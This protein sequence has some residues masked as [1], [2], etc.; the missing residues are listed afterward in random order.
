MVAP[1]EPLAAAGVFHRHVLVVRHARVHLCARWPSIAAA[2]HLPLLVQKVLVE[3][4][5]EDCARDRRHPVDLR[6]EFIRFCTKLNEW[7]RAGRI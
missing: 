7:L 1:E 6:E 2:L 3:G 5:A 4:R